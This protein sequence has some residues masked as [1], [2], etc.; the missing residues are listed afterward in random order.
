MEKTLTKSIKSQILVRDFGFIVYIDNWCSLKWNT[1][2]ENND[3][4]LWHL[5]TFQSIPY[6]IN[7]W[8]KKENVERKN[9]LEIAK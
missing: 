5:T 8:K 1:N 4:H 2:T 3:I 9:I 7:N 6:K